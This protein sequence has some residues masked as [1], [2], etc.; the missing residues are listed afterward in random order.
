MDAACNRL[1]LAPTSQHRPSPTP[2]LRSS[3]RAAALHLSPQSVGISRFRSMKFPRM[4]RVFDHAA[5]PHL[6]PCRSAGCCLPPRL[7]ASAL[8]VCVFRGSIPRLRLRL[9]TLRCSPRGRPRMTRGQNDWLGLSCAT[10]S[11]ATSCSLSG[12]SKRYARKDARTSDLLSEIAEMNQTLSEL[13]SKQG[14]TKEPLRTRTR[15]CS[16]CWLPW[17]VGLPGFESLPIRK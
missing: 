12:A 17:S 3:R 1:W 10:L 2:I 4:L 9:S 11:F 7:T 16:W 13:L 6:L 8:R 15:G 14:A 5:F